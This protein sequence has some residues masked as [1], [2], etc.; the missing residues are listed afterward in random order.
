MLCCMSDPSPTMLLKVTCPRGVVS[1]QSIIVQGTDGRRFEARVPPSIGPGQDFHLRVP[2]PMQPAGLP[3]AVASRM[4]QVPMGISMHP[5]SQTQ[6]QPHR[7]SAPPPA[8]TSPAAPPTAPP[9]PSYVS[10]SSVAATEEEQ[11]A[12]AIAASQQLAVAK[13]VLST[14]AEAR[15]MMECAVCFEDLS[16]ET[17]A[18]FKKGSRRVCA[19]LLHHRCALELPHR[20]CPYC[21]A[22]FEEATC[23]PTLDADPEGW[24][25]CA[26]VEGDGR[27]SK[28]QVLQLLLCQFPLDAQKFEA[29]MEQ[30]WPTFDLDGSGYINRAQFFAPSH[31]LLP[32]A[33]EHLDTLIRTA[34]ADESAGGPIPCIIKD[35]NGWF[36]HF[37]EAGVG[38][39]DQ[40]ELVRALIKTNHLA[41]DL[42]QVREVRELVSAVWGLFADGTMPITRETFLRPGEGL[43]DAIIAALSSAEPPQGL[44]EQL[45][46]VSLSP[47]RGAAA[48]AA[49]A[50]WGASSAACAVESR[51][52]GGGASSAGA[53]ELPPSIKGCP[54]CG[55][56]LEK[57]SGSDEMMCGC[58]ARIAGGTPAKA[59]AA[60]GCAHEF[61]FRTGKPLPGVSGR[62]GYPL[63]DRQRLFR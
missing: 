57:I 56:L 15:Q 45:A 55:M 11:I 3:V 35:R 33:K 18:I 41:T 40:E 46:A 63:N 8:A 27:L 49:A 48:A 38:S 59:L 62:P 29:S 9:L 50:A 51:G 2:A 37:D 19:H 25:R 7:P 22:E 4:P 6:P 24:F 39:L 13:P 43:A 12:M 5:Q 30:L 58:E 42:A 10:R 23:L 34:P 20:S 26:D 28:Q 31:G 16:S 60:G 53:P 17:C 61:N 44:S 21:R 54:A 1:G 14:A 52:V 36:D 47:A 32:Y